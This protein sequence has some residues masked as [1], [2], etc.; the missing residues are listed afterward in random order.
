[1][2]ICDECGDLVLTGLLMLVEADD[3]WGYWQSWLCSSCLDDITSD[4]DICSV[5]VFGFMLDR[6]A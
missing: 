6:L 1:M 2:D 4:C 5:T 3:Q